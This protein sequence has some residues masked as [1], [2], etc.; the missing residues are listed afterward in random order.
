MVEVVVITITFHDDNDGNH[1]TIFINVVTCGGIRICGIKDID[2]VSFIVISII[3]RINI[4]N[5]ILTLLPLYHVYYVASFVIF[6]EHV[7]I[8]NP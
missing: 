5:F 1:R 8:S 2:N 3:I 6:V 4:R 7:T